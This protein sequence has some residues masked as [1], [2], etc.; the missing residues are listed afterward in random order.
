MLPLIGKRPTETSFLVLCPFLAIVVGMI[1]IVKVH[2]QLRCPSVMLVKRDI[3]VRRR[4]STKGNLMFLA[5]DLEQND[6]EVLLPP[7]NHQ[8]TSAKLLF[9]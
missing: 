2:L 8:I 3:K 7:E 4:F 1:S 5:K 6:F 9:P